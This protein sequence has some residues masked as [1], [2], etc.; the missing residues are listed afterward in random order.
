MRK[1]PKAKE[2]VK[3]R[4]RPTADGSQSLYL[5]IYQNGK[6]RYEFLKLYLVPETTPTAKA[7]NAQTLKAA[8]AIKAAR[9]VELI[10]AKAG[11]TDT[12]ATAKITI[13]ELITAHAERV[14]RLGH[15]DYYFRLLAKHLGKAVNLGT[16][17]PN[18]GKAEILRFTDYLKNSGLNPN[19]AHSYIAR[20][21]TVLAEAERH[22]I[23]TKSP[24]ALLDSS[25]RMRPEKVQREYLTPD[26]VQTLINA[27]CGNCPHHKQIFLFACFCGLRY[28]DLVNLKWGDIT[29]DANG[30]K[31]AR[32]TQKKTKEPLL[33]PLCPDAL[34][35]MPPRPLGSADDTP[36]F[37][38]Y[39]HK[40]IDAF[41]LKWTT[42][43]GI[44]KR[45]SIHTARHTFAT[46]LIT[47]GVDIY[48][49]SKLLG[50]TNV[51]TTEIYAKLVDSKK[52][53]AVE[54]FN[55]KFK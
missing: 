24:F 10:H 48:T 40:A 46:M 13:G 38:Q 52:V 37:A 9:N 19:S 15:K 43:N 14:K 1:P 6:R 39:T 27:D 4:M 23:I 3:L 5:D 7:Q 22:G 26:E 34:K 54:T 47:F 55:G 41:L 25:E 51:S 20:L 32:I 2:P 21:A 50:H 17:L 36:I 28:S 30:T 53:E 31:I 42:A 44:K 16:T 18:F 12:T 29:T 49:T 11:L 45:V 33:L 8:T 35:W